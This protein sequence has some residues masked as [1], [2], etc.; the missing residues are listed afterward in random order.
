MKRGYGYWNQEV[1]LCNYSFTRSIL[2]IN[3]K[4]FFINNSGQDIIRSFN[5]ERTFN[6][7]IKC[8]KQKYDENEEK[9][10][11]YVIEY[12]DVLDREYGLRL[13][14]SEQKT[15]KQ[16]VEISTNGIYPKVASIE[17]TERCN[18]RCL[19]CYGE[20]C[21]ELTHDIPLEKMKKLLKDLKNIGTEVIEITGGDCSVHKNLYE[22]LKYALTLHFKKINVL[23]NGLKIPEKVKEIIKQHGDIFY[24]QIDVHSLRNEYLEWF[25]Q[26]KVNCQNILENIK[27][28]AEAGVPMRIAT[29]FTERNINEVWDIAEFVNSCKVKWGISPVE[30]MGRADVKIA[31]KDIYLS[32]ESSLRLIEEMEKINRKYPNLI[33]KRDE[34]TTSNENNC[35]I[36]TDHVVINARGYVKLCTMD[37]MNYF[38]SS[39]GNALEKN[40]KEI[41]DDNKVFTKA[42]AMQETV[43]LDQ[44]ECKDCE[45][46]YSCAKCI[47]RTLINIK[48]KNFTCEWYKKHLSNVLKKFCYQ[49]V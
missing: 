12:I 22:I 17:I 23:T 20:H 8:L 21:V 35:G 26:T 44:E 15:K 41:Y 4:E 42:L 27:E 28:L 29:V 18:V 33:F 3:D 30:P 38:R 36:L 31:D 14:F 2:Y 7:V 45:Y 9:I 34:K 19:H 39:I 48:K 40:I 25:M 5:G 43:Q 1:K 11:Q 16:C 49:M 46:K 47:L 13:I 32:E 37:N 10:T 6:E 24:V